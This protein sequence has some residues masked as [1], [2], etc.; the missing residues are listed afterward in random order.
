MGGGDEASGWARLAT[1]PPRDTAMPN[2]PARFAALIL[3][4]APLFVQRS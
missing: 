1:F 3:T 2:L 4:F